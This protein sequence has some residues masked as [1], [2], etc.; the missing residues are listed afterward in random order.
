[1]HPDS[2]LSG[3]TC[4]QRRHSLFS[5]LQL[6]FNRL[7]RLGQCWRVQVCPQ[8]RRG[9]LKTVHPNS[10]RDVLQSSDLVCCRLALPA[11]RASTHQPAR[12]HHQLTRCNLNLPRAGRR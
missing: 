10:F 12:H 3:Q 9:S 6:S 2:L 5:N 1:M 7:Q 4:F 8:F 11:S